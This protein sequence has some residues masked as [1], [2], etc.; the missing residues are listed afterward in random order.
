MAAFVLGPLVNWAAGQFV[1]GAQQ[2]TDYNN[3]TNNNNTLQSPV[4]ISEL[5]GA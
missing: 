1:S 2:M 3:N 5:M 4:T